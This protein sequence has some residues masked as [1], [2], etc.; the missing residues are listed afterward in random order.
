[1]RGVR[2]ISPDRQGSS[3][4]EFTQAGERCRFTVPILKVYDVIVITQ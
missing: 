4:L 1:M 2:V 3:E